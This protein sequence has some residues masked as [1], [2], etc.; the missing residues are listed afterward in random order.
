MSS[1]DNYEDLL[2]LY[3]DKALDSGQTAVLM[4][5]IDVCARCRLDFKLYNK[6]V[7]GLEQ[8]E[9]LVPPG[10]IT[11]EVM[12]EVNHPVRPMPLI[13]DLQ[14]QSTGAWF[15][16]LA[17]AAAVVVIT[18]GIFIFQAGQP[19][20]LPMP[21][22][23]AQQDSALTTIAKTPPLVEPSL[24]KRRTSQRIHVRIASG[25]VQV[26]RVNS[27][28]WLHI[29]DADEVG[30]G[31]KIRTLPGATA[32]IE[33]T[34]DKTTLKLR[35]RSLVQILTNAVRVYHGDTWIR[36]DKIGSR[37]QAET[38]NAVAS[39]RGTRYSAEVHYPERIAAYYDGDLTESKV[40]DKFL[41][42]YTRN[43]TDSRMNGLMPML[44]YPMHATPVSLAVQ[45]NMLLDSLNA[46]RTVKTKVQVFE[47][48]VEVASIDPDTK[49]EISTVLVK[50]GY[51]TDVQHMQLA[52]LATITENDFLK[53][54]LPTNSALLQ[55][56]QEEAA[57]SAIVPAPLSD[58]PTTTFGA[59][60]TSQ[61]V[62]DGPVIDA[63]I[64]RTDP[65]YNGVEHR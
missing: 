42:E 44:A 27:S 19:G 55:R 51:Q 7:E 12:T 1:C 4:N 41:D 60:R 16:S 28:Q 30:Y 53:W 46:T 40:V 2:Q 54:G 56:V 48:K 13:P 9:D 5:H 14:P 8:L 43:L 22:M 38:P 10:R 25:D 20:S 49:R 45:V 35:P 15:W 3:L 6:V 52:R 29:S 36:V 18:A 32:R 61:P 23:H 11:S 37:F 59:G 62:D 17:S 50:E 39:V 34:Q 47:S 21:E 24:A 65:D 57:R 26:Q 33:Y 64:D 58:A 63:G 31:D